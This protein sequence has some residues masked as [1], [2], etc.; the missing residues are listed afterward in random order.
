MEVFSQLY[1]QRT[2]LAHTAAI[3]GPVAFESE[4]LSLQ[5]DIC[6]FLGPETWVQKCCLESKLTFQSEIKKFC[7]KASV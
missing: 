3:C 7:S 1:F 2:K 5:K 6:T 4:G